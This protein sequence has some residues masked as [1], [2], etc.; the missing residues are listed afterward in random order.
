MDFPGT[1]VSSI[2]KTDRHN[3]TD[4]LFKMALNTLTLTLL[5]GEHMLIV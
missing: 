5:H 1:P 3:I 4:I 2:N